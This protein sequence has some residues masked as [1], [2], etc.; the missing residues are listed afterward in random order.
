MTDI[1]TPFT[2]REPARDPE[3]CSARVTY[4]YVS[5]WPQSKQCDRKGKYLE[6]DHRWCHQHRPSA[7]AERE[8][9]AIAREIARGELNDP[10]GYAA[11]KLK[12]LDL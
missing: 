1:Y 4:Y 3:R 2:K 7:V 9:K 8:R 10:A 6:G 11:M 5:S 12:E